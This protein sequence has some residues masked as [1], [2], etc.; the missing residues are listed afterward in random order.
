MKMM[1]GKY[2]PVDVDNSWIVPYS[3]L[4]SKIMKAHINL[5]SCSSVVAIKYILIHKGSNP[6]MFTI[7]NKK[8]EIEDYQSG[9]YINS[10]PRM[11][12]ST[13]IIT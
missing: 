9:R 8:D 7:E 3:P 13:N 2:K 6:A 4:V 12:L 1:N 10:K 11:F 5:E